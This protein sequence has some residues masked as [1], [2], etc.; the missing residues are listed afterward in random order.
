MNEFAFNISQFCEGHQMSRAFF[1]QLLKEGRG[2]KV[3]RLGGKRL[4]TAEAAREWRKKLD[5]EAVK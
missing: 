5:T 2:P 4:I 1:Y 3:V